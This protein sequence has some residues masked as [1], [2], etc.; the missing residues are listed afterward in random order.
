MKYTEL[1]KGDILVSNF[2][3]FEGEVTGL[4]NFNAVT[5]ATDL[6]GDTRRI[7]PDELNGYSKKE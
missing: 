6:N 1:K 2:D 4:V 7:Q 3:E 5:Y